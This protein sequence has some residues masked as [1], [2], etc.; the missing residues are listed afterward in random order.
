MR[1][2]YTIKEV[3][4]ELKVNALDLRGF[5]KILKLVERMNSG[6]FYITRSNYKKIK[7]LLYETNVHS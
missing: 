1:Y 3:A 7:Q 5:L 2:I 6:P 4:F